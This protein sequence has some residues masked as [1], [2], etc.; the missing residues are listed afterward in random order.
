MEIIF[1][2]SLGAS[3]GKQCEEFLSILKKLK[4][5]ISTKDKMLN[6]YVGKLYIYIQD[7]QKKRFIMTT[8][9]NRNLE[10]PPAGSKK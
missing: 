1:K 6:F 2:N 8:F 9:S 10:D 4:F 5:Q 3:K 7:K